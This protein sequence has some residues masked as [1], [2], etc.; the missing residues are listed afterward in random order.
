MGKRPHL[1]RAARVQGIQR[2][3]ATLRRTHR[4]K[5]RRVATRKG[6]RPHLDRA[7]RVQGIRRRIATLHRTY[8]DKKRR[9]VTRVALCVLLLPVIMLL[10]VAALAVQSFWLAEIPLRLL[11]F[12][13]DQAAKA[14]SEASQVGS[15]LRAT[16]EEAASLG[17]ESRG[18]ALADESDE[19]GALSIAAESG[20]LS[21]TPVVEETD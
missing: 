16:R 11:G 19:G 20:G 21:I 5:K 4:D 9:V 2:R 1:D 12:G 18:L 6:T 15:Q 10:V 17:L 14:S 13:A 3:I 7:A 8:Q